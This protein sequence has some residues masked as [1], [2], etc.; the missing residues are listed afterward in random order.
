MVGGKERE[1]KRDIGS[2]TNTE[3]RIREFTALVDGVNATSAWILESKLFEDI[4]VPGVEVLAGGRE[5]NSRQ[6]HISSCTY[7]VFWTASTFSSRFM[8]RNEYDWVFALSAKITSAGDHVAGHAPSH[9]MSSALF[10][11]SLN[12]NHKFNEISARAVQ[13]GLSTRVIVGTIVA[14][15]VIFGLVGGCVWWERRMRAMVSRQPD[16]P[17]SE[18]EVGF[19]STRPWSLPR[20]RGVSKGD[21]KGTLGTDHGMGGNLKGVEMGAVGV[22][23]KPEPGEET[24]EGRRQEGMERDDE[25]QMKDRPPESVEV[26]TRRDVGSDGAAARGSAATAGDD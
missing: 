21:G 2:N 26:E 3:L 25:I 18:R 11:R 4:V 5:R 17:E 7:G 24:K 14:A 15:V 10:N 22:K 20:G 9:Q 8:A 12:L 23:Q 16:E 6:V 19:V 1:G 13:F